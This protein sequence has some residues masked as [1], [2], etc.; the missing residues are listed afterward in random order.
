[1]AEEERKLTHLIGI[2]GQNPTTEQAG[3]YGDVVKFS[4]AVSTGFTDESETIWYDVAV[5][6]EGLQESVLA[7]IYK[8]A[9]VAVTGYVKSREYN[10]KTY[11]SI[12][13]SRIGLIEYLVPGQSLAVAT[14][15]K[16]GPEGAGDADW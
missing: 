5:W 15:T 10:D 4:I 11:Y 3:T 7:N 13:G 6:K 2:V 8:G 14:A 1:M 16:P 9:K 12:S